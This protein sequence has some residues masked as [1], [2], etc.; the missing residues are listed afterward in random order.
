MAKNKN[1][2]KPKQVEAILKA[3][4]EKQGAKKDEGKTKK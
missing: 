1:Q 4:L 2:K 3:E